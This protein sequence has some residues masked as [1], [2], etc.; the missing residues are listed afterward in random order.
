MQRINI[1]I[2]MDICTMGA[3]VLVQSKQ[4]YK[5]AQQYK[6]TG[7]A[8][9]ADTDRPRAEL[10]GHHATTTALADIQE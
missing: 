10:W 8:Y 6:V 4:H 3:G 2:K 1:C 7:S 9:M 5:A